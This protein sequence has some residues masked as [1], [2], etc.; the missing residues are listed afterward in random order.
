MT[1]GKL[2]NHVRDGACA[3]WS[4]RPFKGSTPFMDGYIVWNGV[5]LTEAEVEAKRAEW[6]ASVVADKALSDWQTAMADTDATMTRQSEDI[7]G[8]MSETQFNKLPQYTQDAYAAKVT[9][10][11]ERP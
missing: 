8:T 2:I 6:E 10:R 7:I 11:G 9:L 4:P 3:K 1:T 5:P